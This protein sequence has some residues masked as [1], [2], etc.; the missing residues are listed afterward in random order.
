MLARIKNQEFYFCFL[1]NENG[2]IQRK[3]SLKILELNKPV[4]ESVSSFS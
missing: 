4:L 2:N 1:L 3:G